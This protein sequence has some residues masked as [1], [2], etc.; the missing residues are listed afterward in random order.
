MQ[1]G[2]VFFQKMTVFERRINLVAHLDAQQEDVLHEMTPVISTP[3]REIFRELPWFVHGN[4]LIRCKV[5]ERVP[6][7]NKNYRPW[8]FWRSATCK[9]ERSRASIRGPRRL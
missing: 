8:V 4:S 6:N 5:L 7:R 2:K 3:R 9:M 1:C